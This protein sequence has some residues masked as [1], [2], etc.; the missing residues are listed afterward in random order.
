MRQLHARA[1]TDFQ[2]RRDTLDNGFLSRTDERRRAGCILIRFQ[3]DRKHNAAARATAARP[4]LG[5]DNA[6]RQRAQRAVFHIAAHGAVDFSSAF[7]DIR[8]FEVDL[9]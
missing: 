8:V 6:G 9:R 7:S 1:L 2:A 3:I 4:T 5:Q